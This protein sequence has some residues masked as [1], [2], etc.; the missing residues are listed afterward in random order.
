MKPKR[1]PID[2]VVDWGECVDAVEHSAR[3]SSKKSARRMGPVE[4]RRKEPAETVKVW[5]LDEI[6][7][8]ER[9]PRTHP[10]AQIEMLARLMQEH[11]VDQPIVVD[12]AGVIIK[13][14]GRLR[15]ARLAGMSTFPVVVKNGLTEDQ[16][17][18]E[19]ISDNQVSLLAG[20]DH[21]LM[22]LE[23]NDLSLAGYEMSLLGF[24]ST[25]MAQFT[26]GSD[27]NAADEVDRGALLE[28]VDV[29]IA[30]PTYILQTGDH[31]VL[32]QRHH[33][34]VESVITGWNAWVPLLVDGAVFCP[35]PGVFIPFSGRADD[36][37]MIMVQPDTYIAGHILDRFVEV[38]GKKAV[39]KL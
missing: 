29:T 34:L 26:N 6:V 14:H 32:D 11:G 30:E 8:Y 18:A 13:G 9:N 20:W 33:L 35:Y 16:K 2:P 4:M 12:E 36:H 31:Y 39:K 1:K 15:A 3:S 17:R 19:R 25:E 28:L 10:D 22:K 38:K 24:D 21:G 5:P 37:A 27:L 23:M 7:P